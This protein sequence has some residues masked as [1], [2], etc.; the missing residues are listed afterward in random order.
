[1]RFPL[2]AARLVSAVE[3]GRIMRLLSHRNK[4]LCIP[5]TVFQICVRRMALP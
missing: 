2:A 1:M 3:H 4:I 5:D